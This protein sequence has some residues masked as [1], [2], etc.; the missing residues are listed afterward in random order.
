MYKAK[1]YVYKDKVKFD[2]QGII[3][4]PTINTSNR[5]GSV[6]LTKGSSLVLHSMLVPMSAVGHDETLKKYSKKIRDKAED[7]FNA[8]SMQLYLSLQLMLRIEAFQL[9]PLSTP[10]T[11]LV[12]FDT[13]IKGLMP[14]NTNSYIKERYF[15][16]SDE[17]TWSSKRL[18]EATVMLD[19][20]LINISD[21]KT[22][23]IYEPY[24]YFT[25]RASD[26]KPATELQ[27]QLYNNKAHLPVETNLKK[28]IL[29]HYDI[30]IPPN[31]QFGYDWTKYNS[32]E[33]LYSDDN[34][35]RNPLNTTLPDW[36]YTYVGR[37]QKMPLLHQVM[38][39]LA[40]TP[41]D[42][43]SVNMFS[44]YA[45]I[46]NWYTFKESLNV[47]CMRYVQYGGK[48]M[49]YNCYYLPAFYKEVIENSYFYKQNKAA[50]V[51]TL[52]S[53]DYV[54][55]NT[56]GSKRSKESIKV[57]LT[58]NAPERTE[59][60]RVEYIRDFQLVFDN[61]RQFTKN[62]KSFCCDYFCYYIGDPYLS[63]KKLTYTNNAQ[64]RMNLHNCARVKQISASLSTD[65]NFFTS[66]QQR[67]SFIAL[68]NKEISKVSTSG[69][70]ESTTINIGF[71][72]TWMKWSWQRFQDISPSKPSLNHLIK[73]Y[74]IYQNNCR[75]R[76]VTGK[77][78][79][80][81]IISSGQLDFSKPYTEIDF[82]NY[83]SMVVDC[84]VSGVIRDDVFSDEISFKV[85]DLLDRA[86]SPFIPKGKTE[87]LPFRI[88]LQFK[89]PQALVS[90]GF[91]RRTVFHA[92]AFQKKGINRL[93]DIYQIWKPKL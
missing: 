89:L 5:E 26:T 84:R 29:S 9:A 27:F 10:Y 23:K 69:T 78:E 36:I 7:T 60:V 51:L 11:K 3:L 43:N 80:Y 18:F 77:Q 90:R 53:I 46:H 28:Q 71:D 35:N 32:G 2:E 87:K 16:K 14:T 6:K 67:E 68:L 73:P 19:A 66:K 20:K 25:L 1:N 62:N 17:K 64:H 57:L 91:T 33:L 93:M 85:V 92:P 81:A 54:V 65:L 44:N 70:V 38:R 58:H 75:R 40:N 50:I 34:N 30:F 79:G 86:P 13:M 47:F 49:S 31:L 45:T 52:L 24:N 37:K 8:D 63:N 83:A 12:T 4:I 41:V 82:V 55:A 15:L 42:V 74:F 22:M 39:V 88:K 21:R 76:V 61:A 59:L 72:K 56:K 48:G